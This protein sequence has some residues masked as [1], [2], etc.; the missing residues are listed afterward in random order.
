[1]DLKHLFTEFTRHGKFLR[2]WSHRTAAIYLTAFESF[3]RFQ[4]S[5][6]ES[7]YTSRTL[8]KAHLE[9]WVIWMRGRGHSGAGCNVH[10]RSMNSFLAWLKEQEHIPQGLR[11]KLLPD[12]KTP[13]PVFSDVH[14]RHILGFKPAGFFQ[15]RTWTLMCLLLDTGCRIDEILNLRDVPPITDPEIM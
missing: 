12:P 6:C 13:I 11:L 7:D 10:I 14:L 15:L 8:T 4:E 5:Q 9:A 1:M 3:T 2:S